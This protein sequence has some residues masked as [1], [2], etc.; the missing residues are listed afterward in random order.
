VRSPVGVEKRRGWAGR[1]QRGDRR[2]F[3]SG[4][5][6]SE[7][8]RGRPGVYKREEGRRQRRDTWRRMREGPG[9]QHRLRTGGG[10]WHT[11]GALRGIVAGKERVEGPRACGPLWAHWR[12]PA[13]T[14][15]DFFIF[16]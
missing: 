1:R 5:G 8:G 6:W 12:G 3:L 9:G 2:P 7:G 11:T 13:S 4:A 10:G 15:S 16:I 14:N